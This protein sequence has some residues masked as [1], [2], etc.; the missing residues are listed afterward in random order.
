[1][2]LGITLLEFVDVLKKSFNLVSGLADIVIEL[3][4]HLVASVDLRLEILDGAVD[5]A[6]GAL[7]GIVL[8]LLFFEMSLQ[9]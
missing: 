3:C 1:M 6:K 8:A 9:L 7:L 5:I 4:I 2:C